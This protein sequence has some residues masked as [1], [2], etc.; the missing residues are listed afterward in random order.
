[1]EPTSTRRNRPPATQVETLRTKYIAVV[2]DGNKAD[3][4]NLEAI[5]RARAGH[6]SVIEM[7]LGRGADPHVADND[8]HVAA[9]F[10]YAPPLE[11]AKARGEL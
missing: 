8:G 7:L 1:M 4:A 5:E 6:A 9:D 10:A 2:G 11:D 3:D